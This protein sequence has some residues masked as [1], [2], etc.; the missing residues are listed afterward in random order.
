MGDTHS[1]ASGQDILKGPY[2]WLQ[3]LR[4]WSGISPDHPGAWQETHPFVSPEPGLQ[5]SILA[6]EPE[7]ALGISSSPQNMFWG[8]NIQHGDYS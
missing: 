8:P 3:T 2:P 6:A 1:G 7:T 4:E 5:T